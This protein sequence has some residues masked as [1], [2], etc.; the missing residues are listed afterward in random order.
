MDKA[1]HSKVCGLKRVLDHKVICE[2][3]NLCITCMD[4]RDVSRVTLH[5]IHKCLFSTVVLCPW[6]CHL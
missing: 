5:V 6:S 2:T 4:T 1:T 3:Y